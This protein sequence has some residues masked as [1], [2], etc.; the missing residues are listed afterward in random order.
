M[1]LLYGHNNP[2]PTYENLTH[3]G[4]SLSDLKEA[5]GRFLGFKDDQTLWSSSEYATVLRVIQRAYRQYLHPTPQS[6]DG[7]SHEWSW[8]HPQGT[9]TVWPSYSVSSSRAITGVHSAGLTTLTANTAVFQDSMVGED[10]VITTVGTF[11]IRS[12]VSA[13]V[14]TVLGNATA[15]ALTYSITTTGDYILPD[16]FGGHD[17]PLTFDAQQGYV[18]VDI[19]SEA[20]IRTLRQRVTS[21]GKP[22]FSATRPKRHDNSAHQRFYLMLYPTPDGEYDLTYRYV[23]NRGQLTEASPYPM[24]M[25]IASNA[26]LLLEMCLSIAEQDENDEAGLHSAKSQLLLA[27]AIESDRRNG[28]PETLGLN[29]DPAVGNRR[30]GYNT[31]RELIAAMSGSLVTYNG[32]SYP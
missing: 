8:S 27:A 17:G 2:S 23:S 7:R 22:L 29:L 28:V 19:V 6:S 11:E 3:L 31:R 30:T 9:V 24:G 21:S 25:H 15:A 18:P 12:V 32:T 5:V 1:I 26:E 10:I 20:Q 16:D 13:T 14:A 4:V